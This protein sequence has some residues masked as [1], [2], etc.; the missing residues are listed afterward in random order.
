[1]ELRDKFFD[2]AIQKYMG[3]FRSEFIDQHRDLKAAIHRCQHQAY[4]DKE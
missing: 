2:E 4:Q 1:M 3:K